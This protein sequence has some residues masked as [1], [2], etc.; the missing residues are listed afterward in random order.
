MEF[1]QPKCRYCD[2]E[3]V[4]E[5]E[6]NFCSECNSIL[7]IKF[8][9]TEKEKKQIIE[10]KIFTYIKDIQ[11]KLCSREDLHDIEQKRINSEKLSDNEEKL[12]QFC[13]EFKKIRLELETF[14]CDNIKFRKALYRFFQLSKQENILSKEENNG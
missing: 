8:Y 2:S 11:A 6:V 5:G 9:E 4:T 1:Y 3:L 12:V 13:L 14:S 10:E 7:F